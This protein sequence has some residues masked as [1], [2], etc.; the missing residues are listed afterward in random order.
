MSIGKG[1]VQD[2]VQQEVYMG[3]APILTNERIYS[4][5]A[6][7]L[8]TSGIGIAS[9]CYTQGGWVAS[10]LPIHL[11]LF[12]AVIPMIA[13]AMIM[14]PVTT[15]SAKY[16]IESMLLL[17]SVFGYKFIK[18][19]W[20]ILIATGTGWYAINAD[21]F[22]GSMMNLSE[23]FGYSINYDARPWLAS[24][25]IIVGSL[26][27]INGPQ[28]LKKSLFVMVPTLLGVG[29]LLMIKAVTTTT[30]SELMAV[31]PVSEGLYATT[32]IAFIIMLEGSFAFVFCWYPVL[33]QF[34]RLAKS[35][36][37]SFWAHTFGYAV[38][39]GFF[40]C[41]G[42]VTATLMASYGAYSEDPTDWMVKIGGP[43]WGFLSM[44]AIALANITTQATG[45]YCWTVA[46]K[47][48]WTK[49]RYK[50]IVLI[51]CAWLIVLAFA[52][53]IWNYYNVFLAIVAVTCGVCL[54]VTC[55]DYFLLRKSKFSLK[56][57]YQIKGH[58]AYNYTGG[59]NI[60]SVISLAIGAMV[61]F[62]A[63]D[64]IN[65]APR[66]ELLFYITPSAGSFFAALLSYYLLSRIPAVKSY[67][68]K[69]REEIQQL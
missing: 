69:D 3:R 64:P 16:G 58:S 44:F 2:M 20:I 22:A 57:I 48:L 38:T 13:M 11:A 45:M 53:V 60:I 56:S 6:L 27:A 19:I 35:R 1:S 17:Q 34:S 46:T 40:V 67:L 4:F 55:S 23:Y 15:V 42:I 68:L 63:Y 8:T 59:F 36:N 47:G 30:W 54:A 12:V 10:C 43:F 26:F 21:L 62:L 51:Y 61:Y 14:M 24:V 7:A 49:L 9:W 31:T 18:I 33:G 50:Q 25:C 52:D 32:G 39:M 29:V 28:L 41:I 65:Y 37:H 66:N 5:K